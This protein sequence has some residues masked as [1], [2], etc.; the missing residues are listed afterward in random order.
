MSN[1]YLCPILQDPQFNDDGS[2]MVGGQIW[3]YE[4]GTTTPLTAYQDQSA[5]VAWPNPIILDSR[6]ET[7]GEIWLKEGNYYKLIVESAPMAGLEHGTVISDF[8]NISGV[9]DPSANPLQADWQ[10]YSTTAPVYL[11][12]STFSLLGDVTPIFTANRRIKS[13]CTAG[14][15][16][17]TVKSSAYDGSKT[18][19]TLIMDVNSALDNGM[20][21]IYY[22]FIETS[23]SSIPVAVLT[24][25]ST[26]ATN[27]NIKVGYD[28]TWLTSTVDSTDFG[29]NWPI[30]ISGSA[31]PVGSVIMFAAS[32]PPSGYLIA[33]GAE[34]SR[35]TY[36]GLY[37]VIGTTFGDGDGSLTFNLPDMRGYFA[38]GWDS[39]GTVDKNISHQDGTT[40]VSS[41]SVTGLITKYLKAGMSVSGPG[42]PAAT[43]ISSISNSTDIDLSAAVVAISGTTTNAS[44]S[45]TGI[46]STV[47]I[48]V[49]STITGTGIPASTIVIAVNTSTSI[50]ISNNATASG[51]VNIAF[52]SVSLK[53]SGTRSFGS[54]Q[55]DTNAPITV[56][57]PGHYHGSMQNA[58]TETGVTGGDSNDQ[59][60]YG[61]TDNAF[62]GISIH[63][64]G[65][66][67]R[68]KNVALLPC[69]KY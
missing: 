48:V 44:T 12:A 68:P 10:R 35:T 67:S 32:T 7:G 14:L 51:T 33:N 58:G 41:T 49:G 52:S 42:V 19:V 45:I 50:T 39:T 56:S 1:A 69:I 4:A 54:Y 28:G 27:A 2:F 3:F 43:T 31:G 34:V 46:S 6:G 30:N 59:S 17:G 26:T 55:A 61:V 63:N 8:D 29:S 25:T 16:T 22:G 40:T 65:S 38:R 18:T 21:D 36:A 47:G 23:P 13:D 11:T 5:I 62:T 15:Q 9:N 37:A 60:F 20:S 64:Q 57:D 66:E 53:F 24:G